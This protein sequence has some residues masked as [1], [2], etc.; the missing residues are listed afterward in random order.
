[1]VILLHREVARCGAQ[2]LA[3]VTKSTPCALRSCNTCAISSFVSPRPVISRS[4]F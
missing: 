3:I 1:M 2:I 4:W